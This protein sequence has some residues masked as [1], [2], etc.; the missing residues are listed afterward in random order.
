[1]SSI[2]EWLKIG[3]RKRRLARSGVMTI[4]SGISSDAPGT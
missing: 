4:G 1:L 3:A 2:S